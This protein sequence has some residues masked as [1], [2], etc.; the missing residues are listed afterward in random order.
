VGWRGKRVRFSLGEEDKEVGRQVEKKPAGFV[1]GGPM[2]RHQGRKLRDVPWSQRVF[3]PRYVVQYWMKHYRENKTWEI[4]RN[5]KYWY[6]LGTSWGWDE[7]FFLD[8]TR[9]SK[10]APWDL[11]SGSCISGCFCQ[12][13]VP[14]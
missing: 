8:E 4:Y 1:W 11:P 6:D 5:L 13:S 9:F 2:L 3:T 7:E 10:K 12:A 14:R